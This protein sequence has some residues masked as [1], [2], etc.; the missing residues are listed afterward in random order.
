[1]D[2]YILADSCKN[3]EMR[4]F[5]DQM[6]QASSEPMSKD[7]RS[8]LNL[9]SVAVYI[10][11]SGTTG[12]PLQVSGD[13]RLRTQPLQ[14]VNLLF[15]SGRFTQS[16]RGDSCQVVVPG[17]ASVRIDPEVQRRDLYHPPSLPHRRLP[18][19]HLGHPDGY[20]R[21]TAPPGTHTDAAR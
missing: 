1:M 16:G 19:S 13:R 4:S 21:S 5:R 6:N 14:V 3:P 11:T 10:Y 8:H 18:R 7:L 17:A 9:G 20:E 2:I 15:L 12:E